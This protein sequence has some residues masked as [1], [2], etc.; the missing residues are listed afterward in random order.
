DRIRRRL[1]RLAGSD[2]LRRVDPGGG[3]R[4]RLRSA[5]PEVSTYHAY[6]G[7]LLGEYGLL[8][9]MEP[10]VRMLGETELWQT[11]HRVVSSWD[12]ELDTE[13]NPATITE[14]VLR[15]SNQL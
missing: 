11:A 1:A 14:R 12:G 3:I 5:E 7:R 9:P 8:L 13:S 10:S 4:D 6:A 2:L 15:L